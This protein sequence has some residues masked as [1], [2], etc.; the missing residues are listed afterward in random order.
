MRLPSLDR[1]LA[2]VKTSAPADP[3]RIGAPPATGTHQISPTVLCTFSRFAMIAL[4]SGMKATDAQQKAG[5][6]S[7]VS[8]RT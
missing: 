7:A 3:S 5:P 2:L 6:A 8:V 1:S 4:P